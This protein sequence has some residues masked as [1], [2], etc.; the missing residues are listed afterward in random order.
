MISTILAQYVDVY[1]AMVLGMLA[2]GGFLLVV[3]LMTK[4]NVTILF[5]VFV[6]AFVA[7]H[8]FG[9]YDFSP[10]AQQLRPYWAY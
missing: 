8:L 3:H 6:V 4:R 9:H 10:P 7:M 2:F 1:R 5:I